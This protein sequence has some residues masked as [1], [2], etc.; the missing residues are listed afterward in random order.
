MKFTVSLAAEL[1][2]LDAALDDPGSDIGQGLVQLAADV[3]GAVPS[4]AA[5]SVVVTRDD[6]SFTLTLLDDGVTVADVGTSIM[7]ARPDC[8]DGHD[9]S[10][11]A[12][13]L[14]SR[15]PGAFVDLAADVSWLTRRPLTDFLL[16]AHLAAAAE[17]GTA[18]PLE[19]AS[20][21]NQ[22]IGVLIGRGC[23]PQQ[24]LLE[25]D[26]QT[27]Q[28]ETDRLSVGRVILARL[29]PRGDHRCYIH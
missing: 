11:V 20:V 25:L 4:Y 23:T 10:A 26:R 2:T 8:G 9:A 12:I 22:A 17:P 5:L 1:A 6:S 28:N 3:T 24:A 16:D 27:A 14:Y 21:I 15:S 13:I 7:L 18:T 29:I 19:A